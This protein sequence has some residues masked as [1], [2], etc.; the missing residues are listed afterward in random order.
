MNNY[1]FLRNYTFIFILFYFF[2]SCDRPGVDPVPKEK[3]GQSSTKNYN[4]SDLEISFNNGS[5]FSIFSADN[6]G[7]AKGK[8]TIKEVKEDHYF[9]TPND[10]VFDFSELQS[11]YQFNFEYKLPANLVKNDIILFQ[12]SPGDSKQEMSANLVSFKY[13]QNSG[14]LT[15]SVNM[16]GNSSGKSRVSAKE[17]SENVKGIMS[18][19]GLTWGNRNNVA[20]KA[21]E[22]QLKL[23]FYEQPGGT[24]W[25]TSAAMIIKAYSK[26]NSSDQTKNIIDYVKYMNHTTLDEGLGLWDFKM[27][28]T[29]VININSNTKAE[30]SSFISSTNML[31]TIIDKLN[32]GKPLIMNLSYP[33]IGKH[34]VVVLGYKKEQISVAKINV[35]LLI[36]NPQNAGSNTMYQ[37]VDWEWLMKDKWPQE[38][39]QLLYPV[40]PL[41]QPSLITLGLP[42]ENSL[43]DLYFKVLSPRNPKASASIKLMYSNNEKKAWFWQYRNQKIEEFPDSTSSIEFNLPV[44]NASQERVR[45]GLT[46]KILDKKTKKIVLEESTFANVSGGTYKFKGS[47]PLKSIQGSEAFDGELQVEIFNGDTGK[48]LDG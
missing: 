36:H 15:A 6:P 20:Q 9:N 33:G 48:F 32:E 38:V 42:I 17:S 12:Y 27:N 46:G 39:Y 31:E 23:P 18:R 3:M 5:K 24:C 1:H 22:V 35:K 16:G 44:Y 11:G 4:G 2:I 47:I 41:A 8:I 25:A 10:L 40:Q 26:Q 19:L 43:G 29:S 34:A 30:V 37:W 13:D 7:A 21:N 14:L 28:L 45:V